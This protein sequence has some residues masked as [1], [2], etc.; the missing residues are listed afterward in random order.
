[1]KAFEI[2]DNQNLESCCP[3]DNHFNFL[4]SDTA[5]QPNLDTAFKNTEYA[6]LNILFLKLFFTFIK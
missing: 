4:N 6:M 5:C 2:E 1:M 3:L